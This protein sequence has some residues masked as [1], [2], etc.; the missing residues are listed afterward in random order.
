MSAPV[1]VLDVLS[2]MA[3]EAKAWRNGCAGDSLISEQQ[4]NAIAAIAELFEAG[5]AM[6][7]FLDLHQYL[8]RDGDVRRFRAALRAC[9]GAA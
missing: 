2:T 1:D 8:D 9:G 6:L 5:P 3:R 4:E 7:R